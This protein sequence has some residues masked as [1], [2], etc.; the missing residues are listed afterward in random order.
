MNE[1]RKE[2]DDGSEFDATIDQIC[3]ALQ[4]LKEHRRAFMFGFVIEGVDKKGKLIDD[5]NKMMKM[6]I[7]FCRKIPPD[8]ACLMT[9]KSLELMIEENI[10]MSGISP[11]ARYQYMIGQ[12]LVGPGTDK[13]PDIKIVPR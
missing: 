12:K 5:I 1:E 3:Q 8:L 6:P 11:A 10:D 4:D 9:M 13:P 7:L 2:P